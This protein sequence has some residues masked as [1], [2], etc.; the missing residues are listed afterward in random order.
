MT[1]LDTDTCILGIKLFAIKKKLSTVSWDL[2]VPAL[3][4]R[5]QKILHLKQTV[6]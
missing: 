6:G 5:A 2:V 3:A 1:I 4:Y